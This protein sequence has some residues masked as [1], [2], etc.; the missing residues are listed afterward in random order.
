MPVWVVKALAVGPGVVVSVVVVALTLAAA[1]APTAAAVALVLAGVVSAAGNG[2]W[3]GPAAAIVLGARR[4]RPSE[5]DELAAVLTQLCR[6]GLGPPLV[7]LRVRQSRVIGAIGAG[8]RTVVVSTGLIEAVVLGELPSRQAAAVVAHSAV[9]VREGLTRADLLIGCTSAPWRAT[10][11]TVRAVS[12]WGRRLPFTQAAW[13]LRVVVVDVAVVQAVQVGRVGLAVT[14]AAI[15]AFSY[16]LPVWERRWHDLLVRAGDEGVAR[17]GFGDGLVA[18]LR[19][20]P[21]TDAARARLRALVPSGTQRPSL[22]P[23]TR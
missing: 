16:A 2:A 23:V 19:M 10:R 9:L 18:F 17:A 14:I 5:R 4:L 21:R 22:G 8:R 3:E 11:A 20:C 1:P 6:V 7:E 13:R 15:G 12:S